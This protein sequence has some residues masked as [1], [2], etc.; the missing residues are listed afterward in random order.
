MNCI[1]VYQFTMDFN[2][3]RYS[4]FDKAFLLAVDIGSRDLF[5]DIHYLAMD[6]G[7]TALAEVAKRKADQV[8]SASIGTGVNASSYSC[9]VFHDNILLAL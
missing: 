9:Y 4:R 3:R 8:E 1:P 5:M 7:E 2:V 6:K